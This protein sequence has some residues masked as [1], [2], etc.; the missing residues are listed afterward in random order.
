MTRGAA[1]LRVAALAVAVIVAVGTGRTAAQA[2]IVAPV[3]P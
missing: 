2:N 1:L 3:R